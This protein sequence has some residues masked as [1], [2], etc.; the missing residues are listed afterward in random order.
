MRLTTLDSGV[1]VV[2]I[3]A[4]WAVMM[5]L[6]NTGNVYAWGKQIN[7]GVDTGYTTLITSNI[8]KISAS[9]QSLLLLGINGNAYS[10]GAGAVSSNYFN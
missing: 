7:N 10:F 6:S 1:N 3:S 5:A 9:D 8:A 4:G 2:D